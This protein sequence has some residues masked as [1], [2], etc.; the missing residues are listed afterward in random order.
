MTYFSGIPR[1][2]VTETESRMLDARGWRKNI[3]GVCVRGR[4]G[5]GSCC[6]LGTVSV[7]QD[8]KSSGDRWW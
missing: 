1:V 3:N 6:L 4:W 7:L 5:G 8:E 2:N